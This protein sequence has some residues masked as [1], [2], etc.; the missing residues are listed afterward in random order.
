MRFDF[1]NLE[2]R[3]LTSCSENVKTGVLSGITEQ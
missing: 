2:I 3:V 1:N